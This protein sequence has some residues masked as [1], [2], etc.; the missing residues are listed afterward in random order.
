MGKYLPCKSYRQQCCCSRVC[1]RL[2][3]A[4]CRLVAPEGGRK[5]CGAACSSR[6]H[7][8][9]AGGAVEP[10]RLLRALETQGS[11]SASCTWSTSK[12]GSEPDKCSQ[13][14]ES[15][16]ARFLTQAN[17]ETTLTAREAALAL[18]T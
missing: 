4:I 6:G 3:Q 9:A 12:Q 13:L 7:L 2:R 18:P 14:A 15:S 1:S 16:H 8:L 5:R 11:T 17:S 10:S